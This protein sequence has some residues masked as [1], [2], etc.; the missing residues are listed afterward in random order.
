M[1]S[2]ERS[3]E[4]LY[5]AFVLNPA[6]Q[7]MFLARVRRKRRTSHDGGACRRTCSSHPYGTWPLAIGSALELRGERAAISAQ[8]L[9]QKDRHMFGRSESPHVQIADIQRGVRTLDRLLSRL[10]DATSDLSRD[11]ID[12]GREAAS[13]TFGAVAERFRNGAER[14]G[15]EAMR[16]GHR[17][18]AM[19]V[20]RFAKDVG[21]PPLMIVGIALGL[22]AIV[23]A[24]RYR[25]AVENPK[26]A[27]KRHTVARR[28]N[29]K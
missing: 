27:R 8:S 21:I 15:E 17:A 26:P 3:L 18:S 12:R 22:G 7:G 10:S 4:P 16:L 29:R 1:Q 2:G 5:P 28:G 14:A 25:H 13:D 24:A 20:D 23:G 19:S 11:A 6:P 9:T